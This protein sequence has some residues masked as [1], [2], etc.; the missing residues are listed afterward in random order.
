M[1]SES[2]LT[3]IKVATGAGEELDCYDAEIIMYINS[4]LATLTQVGIGPEKGFS[5]TD[6]NDKWSD[7]IS[8]DITILSFVKSYI[9]I[10]VKLVFDTPLSSVVIAALEKQA[11]EFEWRLGVAAD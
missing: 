5:I 1:E 7:F 9:A 6:A 10:K 2:I 3:S 4:M 11:A 8:D